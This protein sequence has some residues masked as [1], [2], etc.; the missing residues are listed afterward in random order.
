M[1]QPCVVPPEAHDAPLHVCA[2]DTQLH[3]LSHDGLIKRHALEAVV[4]ANYNH[5]K[6]LLHQISLFPTRASNA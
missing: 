4:L 6:F 2:G 1:V 3:Q 5:Q